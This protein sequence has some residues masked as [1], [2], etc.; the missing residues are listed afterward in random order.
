M[1]LLN[2]ELNAVVVVVAADFVAVGSTVAD[3]VAVDSAVV[4][5]AAGYVIG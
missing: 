4:G 3:F 1:V 5:F 2:H